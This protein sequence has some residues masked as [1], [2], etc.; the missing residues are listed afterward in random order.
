MNSPLTARRLTPASRGALG[1]VL[2]L[3]LLAGAVGS[4]PAAANVPTGKVQGKVVA[5]D[6]GDPIAY[7][8]VVLIPADSTMHPV[9]GLTNSDGTFLLV[10]PA[11]RYTLRVR[12]LSYAVQRIADVVVRAGDHVYVIDVGLCGGRQSQAGYGAGQDRRHSP[13]RKRSG[14]ETAQRLPS[15]RRCYLLR[16]SR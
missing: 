10:A 5:T 13:A 4:A 2:T 11:G 1:V 8:D 16:W 15:A 14:R 3:A 9:G 7:A 12:A 6:S